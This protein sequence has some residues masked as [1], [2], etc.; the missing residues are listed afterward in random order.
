MGFCDREEC[1]DEQRA[2]KLR[3]KYL[4]GR[5]KLIG[6]RTNDPWVVHKCAAALKG[7]SREWTERKICPECK[8]SGGPDGVTNCTTCLTFWDAPVTQADGRAEHE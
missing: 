8:A 3:V 2:L 5:L 7:T 6:Q 1:E 4:E